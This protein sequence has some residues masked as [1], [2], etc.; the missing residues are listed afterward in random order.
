MS[1]VDLHVALRA[2]FNFPAFRPGQVEAIQH[3][4]HGQHTLVVMPTGSG[5]SLI[6][7]LAALQL[8][9]VTLV[10][11]PLIALM[12]DQV[13]GLT[14]R[15]LAATFINSSLAASEQTD[16]IRALAEGRFKIVLVAPER[17][18]SRAFRQ[19]LSHIPISLLTV[20]EAQQPNDAHSGLCGVSIAPRRQAVALP[21]GNLRLAHATADPPDASPVEDPRFLRGREIRSHAQHEQLG[22]G[23]RIRRILIPQ[24]HVGATIKGELRVHPKPRGRSDL[25]GR[26]VDQRSVRREPRQEQAPLVPVVVLD[27][28]DGERRPSNAELMYWP[29]RPELSTEEPTT[30]PA[31]SSTALRVSTS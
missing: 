13:D 19:A 29:C 25:A 5:K 10:I 21:A 4:L 23:G 16:R 22:V 28:Q 1:E 11:S 17:L 9:G 27:P 24:D 7:Q 3:V 8:P 31:R 18:R 26:R 2:H 15:G 12:K 20:D 30:W 14:R 6:Y